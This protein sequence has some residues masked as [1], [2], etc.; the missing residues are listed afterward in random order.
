VTP[1]GLV[2]FGEYFSN[3]RRDEVH[4]YGSHDSGRS[5]EVLY[6]FPKGA[7][8]HVHGVT[9]DPYDD[10]FW[11]TTGDYA[12]EC[13]LLRASKD[14]RTVDTVRRHGQENRFCSVCVGR[15]ALVMAT[16]SP[17]ARNYVVVCDKRSGR[18]ERRQAIENSSFYHCVVGGRIYLSTTA[19]PSPVNDSRASHVWSGRLGGDGWERRLSFPVDLYARLSRLPLLKPGLFQYPRVFFPDGENPG[20]VLV[21]YGIGLKEWDN[22]LLCYDTAA[23]ES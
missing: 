16:D 17:L 9:Y 7:V 10:C 14:F 5:W 8:R 4:V 18:M 13:R 20:N 6:T 2:V 11:V 3:P 1:G 15:D 12:D 22:T 21:C 23:W 19:E